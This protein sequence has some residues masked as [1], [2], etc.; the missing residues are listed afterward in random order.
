MRVRGYREGEDLGLD[1]HTDDS[2]AQLYIGY[3]T[4]FI[5]IVIGNFRNGLPI[6]LLIVAM[7]TVIL[8]IFIRVLITIHVMI[9]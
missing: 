4:L 8:A 5:G 9:I 3:A 7:I 1:M 6:V 2:A